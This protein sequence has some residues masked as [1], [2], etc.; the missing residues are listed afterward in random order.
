V[1]KSSGTFK[2]VIPSKEK[3]NVSHFMVSM[4]FAVA[5]QHL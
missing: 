1:S 4:S 3:I 5:N 2:T